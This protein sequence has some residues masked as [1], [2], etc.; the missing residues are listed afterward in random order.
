MK[1]N[2]PPFETI[3]GHVTILEDK[4]LYINHKP[5]VDSAEKVEQ[6]IN[7]MRA[8]L[9]EGKFYILADIRKTVK[10]TKAAR[11][12]FKTD[13]VRSFAAGSAILVDSGISRILG[14]MVLTF[15]KLPFPSKLFT[16]QEKALSW[17][18]EQKQIHAKK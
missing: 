13:L 14:N 16:N 7:S 3:V 8:I 10:T 17:L 5:V 9:G 11:D 12:T 15:T 4:I 6:H 2:I 18:Q 1:K